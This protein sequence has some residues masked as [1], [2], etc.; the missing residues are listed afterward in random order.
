M[1]LNGF[2]QPKKGLW[3]VEWVNLRSPVPDVPRFNVPWK[4]IGA[5]ALLAILGHFLPFEWAAGYFM[6]LFGMAAL[7]WITYSERVVG[8]N[9]PTF[10]DVANRPL[11]Q[12]LTE[13]GYNPDASPFPGLMG[14]VFNVKAFGAKGDGVTD[15]TTAGQSTL[16]S[17]RKVHFPQGT[18]RLSSASLNLAG[19]SN[20]DIFGAGP[21][22]TVLDATGLLR[23]FIGDATLGTVATL[24]ANVVEGDFTITLTAGGGAAF[25]ANDLALVNDGVINKRELWLIKSVAGDVL[26]LALPSRWNWSSA[27]ATKSV[28]RISNPAQNISIRDLTITGSSQALHFL[29]AFDVRLENV[30]VRAYINKAAFEFD[31]SLLVA[32]SGGRITNGGETGV[33]ALRCGYVT[34]DG[35]TIHDNGFPGVFLAQYV[36]DS[37]VLHCELQR[38]TTYGVILN[39][40]VK[41]SSVEGNKIRGTR[42]D[43][44]AVLDSN[45]YGIAL[46][47]D[48][49]GVTVQGNAV[50]GGNT[51]IYAAIRTTDC[52]IIG[53]TVSGGRKGNA[54]IV[55]AGIYCD[56][57]CVGNTIT[58]NTVR[59]QDEFGVFVQ[60]ASDRCAVVGNTITGINSTT[61]PAQGIRFDTAAGGTCI[62]NTVDYGAA[63]IASTI[64]INI[65]GGSQITVTGNHVTRFARP[66]SLDSARV[67]IAHNVFFGNT[68]NAILIVVQAN[69]QIANNDGH[70]PIGMLAITVTASPF[71]YT[72]GPTQETVFIR[73]GTVSLITIDGSTIFVASPATVELPPNK[74]VVVTYSVAPTMISIGH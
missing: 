19:L 44:G 50:R 1:T 57:N 37:A 17:N 48:V 23:A 7:P 36:S 33:Q 67:A 2:R 54:V 9:H 38:C 14:P 4:A 16:A 46:Q 11:R 55:V 58:G 8:R 66:L 34:V 64:G 13:S 39:D 73:G 31:E 61:T 21:D 12:L 35:T 72:A 25:A 74:A 18:Y 22:A 65:V 29:R 24:G 3:R 62:G 68:S 47:S 42:R 71:T 53:N 59:D 26:T 32:V 28:T 69:C 40:F 56:T 30:V 27:G 43:P 6:P 15:D 70:N 63:P 52:P 20:L 41:R 51:G 45:A 60:T 5:T 10:T 49:D